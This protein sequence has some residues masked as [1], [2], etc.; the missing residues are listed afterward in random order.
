MSEPVRIEL[1]GLR[2]FGP[3]GVSRAEREVGRLIVLDLNLTLARCEA[4]ADD[5]IAGTI[6]YGAVARVATE[7]VTET[8]C[9]TLERLCGRIADRIAAEFGPDEIEVRAAK[10]E[11]PIPEAIGEVAVVLRRPAR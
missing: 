6:D 5:E 9:H 2:A 10:T 11:P 8:S 4:V 3:H 1:R 7:V